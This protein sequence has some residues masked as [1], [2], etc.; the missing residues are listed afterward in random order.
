MANERPLLLFKEIHSYYGSSHVL[1]GV[2][3]DVPA[4]LITA[5]VGRN[6]VGKTTL[7]NVGMGLVPVARGQLLLRGRDLTGM[8]PEARRELGL[9]L[10][11]QGRRVFRSLTV[12]EHLRLVK[13]ARDAPFDLAR[14]YETFPRL[15]E[16]RTSAAVTLSGGEQSMLA[17]ARALTT[18]PTILLMD[19]PTEG[20]APL[21]VDTVR[22]IVEQLRASGLTVLLVEQNLAF[23]RAVA[24]RIAI[25]QRGAIDR[26]I[27]RHDMPDIEA[28]SR[29]ILEGGG[30]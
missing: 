10:V 20:L 3:L 8:P 27:P 29:F 19:E 9:A 1:H 14:I 28:L 6:G 15:R 18:N 26:I 5:V 7:I 17:I 30:E 23:A 11:P 12:E 25:M 24:D 2:S 13:P 4:G 16:R 21:L 22:R